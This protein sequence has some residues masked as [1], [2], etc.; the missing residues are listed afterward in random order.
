M[1]LGLSDGQAGSQKKIPNRKKVILVVLSS[2][3]DLVKIMIRAEV[4]V[5][6]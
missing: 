6:F 3:N 1:L 2:D 5:S 4:M